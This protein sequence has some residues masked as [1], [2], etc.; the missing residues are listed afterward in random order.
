[1]ALAQVSMAGAAAL[2]RGGPEPL[3]GPSIALQAVIERL[4]ER[5]GVLA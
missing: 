5:N 4:G 3:S 2:V 1:V